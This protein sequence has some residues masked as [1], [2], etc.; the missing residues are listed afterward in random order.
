M[1]PM[2]VC[3]TLSA[4]PPWSCCLYGLG[5]MDP[6]QFFLDERYGAERCE[7]MTRLLFIYAKLNPGVRYV[8]GMNEVWQGLGRE[9]KGGG[10]VTADSCRRLL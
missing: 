2:A 7:A 6:C 10:V 9:G 8:Q 3:L 4:F 1:A 5:W